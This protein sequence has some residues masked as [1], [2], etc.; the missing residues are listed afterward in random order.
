[1][2]AAGLAALLRRRCARSFLGQ[3]GGWRLL[4]RKGF[5]VVLV[6]ALDRGRGFEIQERPWLRSVAAPSRSRAAA[7]RSRSRLAALRASWADRTVPATQV[8]GCR[9]RR[10]HNRNRRWRE[11]SA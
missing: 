1:V 7:M 5:R 6:R 10:R 2:T 8:R 3:F 11:Y 9:L 4:G